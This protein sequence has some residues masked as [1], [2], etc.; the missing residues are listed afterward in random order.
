MVDDKIIESSDRHH[1]KHTVRS[2]GFTNSNTSKTSKSD[3]KKKLSCTWHPHP[4]HVNTYETQSHEQAKSNI[5]K[6]PNSEF[7]GIDLEAVRNKRRQAVPPKFEKVILS[8]YGSVQNL[9]SKVIFHCYI[10]I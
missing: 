3:L 6:I 4:I 8:K 9:F 7:P 2:G 10:T 1:S 5:N